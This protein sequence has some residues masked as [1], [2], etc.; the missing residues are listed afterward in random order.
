MLYITLHDDCGYKSLTNIQF[1]VIVQARV[2]QHFPGC[3]E[4]HINQFERMP[5][6][7]E[8]LVVG[9]DLPEDDNF[10]AFAPEDYSLY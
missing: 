2:C 1:P 7:R 3:V 10:Y 9:H 6:F 5:G 8:D 4:V